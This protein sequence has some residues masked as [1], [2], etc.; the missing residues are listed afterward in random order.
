MFKLSEVKDP[1]FKL[2]MPDKADGTPGAVLEYDL[3]ELT[4]KLTR[5]A[6][7]LADDPAA[8]FGMFD[9]IRRAFNFP[10]Q[11]EYDAA[12]KA[13]ADALAIGNAALPVPILLTRNQ[14]L[15][16]NKS[17]TD[18]ATRL[19]EELEGKKKA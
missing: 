6:S 13:S 7:A 8:K 9:V 19:S 18:D 15:Q 14:C 2:Q 4:E 17:V 11:P 1:I 12:V 3:W 10:T 16:L 5:G